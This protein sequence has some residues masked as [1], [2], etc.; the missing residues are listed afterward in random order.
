MNDESDHP[1]SPDDVSLIAG[2][3]ASLERLPASEAADR[4]SSHHLESIHAGIEAGGDPFGRNDV[5]TLSP[6]EGEALHIPVSSLPV[7]VGA[8]KEA[9]H[10]IDGRGVSGI[11]CKIEK[12]GPLL[13]LT[14]LKSKNG[15][16]LNGHPTESTLL[17][18]G[19]RIGL[20]LVEF[21]VVRE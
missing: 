2:L 11:H 1:E 15:T 16:L 14:D 12:D 5:L 17:C 6:A 10:V 18:E 8:G 7:T 21:R 19:D 13:R 3:K 20:G 4:M 9:D